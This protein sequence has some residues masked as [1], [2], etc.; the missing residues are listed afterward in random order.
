ME[1]QIAWK[2]NTSIVF[3]FGRKTPWFSSLWWFSIEKRYF[4]EN[5]EVG[6]AELVFTAFE[7]NIRPAAGTEKEDR[8]L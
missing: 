2:N 8:R 5:R 6:Y 1:I 7:K 3:S 4:T